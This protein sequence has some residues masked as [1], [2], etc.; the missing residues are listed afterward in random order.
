[1]N[2]NE[3][4]KIIRLYCQTILTNQISEL[5]AILKS[6]IILSNYISNIRLIRKIESLK[7]DFNKFRNQLIAIQTDIENQ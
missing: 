2:E 5:E 4:M 3:A 7:I 1:M 6:M